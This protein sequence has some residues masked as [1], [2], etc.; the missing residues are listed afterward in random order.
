MPDDVGLGEALERDA[1]DALERVFGFVEAGARFVFG[2]AS[3]V[4]ACQSW[5]G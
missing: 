5:T 4:A 2:R 3:R 1:L